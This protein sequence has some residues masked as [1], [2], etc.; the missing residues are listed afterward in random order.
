MKTL[1]YNEP[2]RCENKAFH[3][4]SI[5]P[6]LNSPPHYLCV[7]GLVEVS[8]N[9]DTFLRQVFFIII[10]FIP[11]CAEKV[12]YTGSWCSAGR[13]PDIQMPGSVCF[14]QGLKLSCKVKVFKK[15]IYLKEREKERKRSAVMSVVTETNTV[16]LWAGNTKNNELKDAKTIELEDTADTSDNS[17]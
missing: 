10:F 6:S 4:S 2:L 17:L 5:W 14:C 3:I 8:V 12:P 15:N 9:V 1:V 13:A 11:I 7:C 16:K